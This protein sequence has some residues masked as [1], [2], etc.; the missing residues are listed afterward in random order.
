MSTQSNTNTDD[1][2][3][4]SSS[5]SSQPFAW[6]LIPVVIFIFIGVVATIVQIRRRRRRRAALQYPGLGTG[7]SAPAGTTRPGRTTRRGTGLAA[8]RSEEGLNELG[9]A[10]PPY[11]GNK[12]VRHSDE[13]ELRD[14]EA[15]V[16]PPDYPAEPAPAV[17]TESRRSV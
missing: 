2:D 5:L 16:R 9:E 14:M 10:P 12:D 7:Q 13:T 6:V 3:D 11:D 1:N 8:T 17:T 4:S 15:G